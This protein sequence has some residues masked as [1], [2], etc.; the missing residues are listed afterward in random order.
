MYCH[1][2]DGVVWREEHSTVACVQM[3]DCNVNATTLNVKVDKGVYDGVVA[4]FNAW[5]LYVLYC[6]LTEV[7]SIVGGKVTCKIANVATKFNS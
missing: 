4:K 1:W 5:V 7:S 2:I 3:I 6:I